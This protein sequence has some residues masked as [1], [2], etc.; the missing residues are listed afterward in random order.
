M[1]VSYMKDMNRSYMVLSGEDQTMDYQIQ[2]LEKNEIPGLLPFH[3][4]QVDRKLQYCYEVSGKNQMIKWLEENKLSFNQVKTVI[5]T[6]VNTIKS[7]DSYLLSDQCLMLEEEYI[8]MDEETW[9][10][11]FCYYPPNDNKDGLRSLLQ[12]ILKK[13]DHKDPEAVFLA[14]SLFQESFNDNVSLVKLKEIVERRQPEQWNEYKNYISNEKQD[15][16]K[17]IKNTSDSEIRDSER[18]EL[19]CEQYKNES[20]NEKQWKLPEQL[21]VPH[22]ESHINE[23]AE[24]KII[25][26][27]KKEILF[28]FNKKE[29]NAEKIWM[30]VPFITLIAV[31]IIFSGKLVP[32]QKVWAKYPWI[33]MGILLFVLGTNVIIVKRWYFDE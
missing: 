5:D 13:I 20:Y 3:I 7:L 14:Y 27:K 26:E 29:L 15:Y 10:I 9:E 11:Y 23:A 16:R 19:K 30:A 31:I 18:V 12:L 2:M 22:E 4:E 1:E 28:K 8:Y 25:K 33:C 6:L 32:I 24:E 17:N 21:E